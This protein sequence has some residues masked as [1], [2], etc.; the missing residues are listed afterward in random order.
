MFGKRIVTR[1]EVKKKTKTA[2]KHRNTVVQL[3]RQLEFLSPR[4]R[5]EGLEP[6]SIAVMKG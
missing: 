5:A 6:L 3:F 2:A 1:K 4:S